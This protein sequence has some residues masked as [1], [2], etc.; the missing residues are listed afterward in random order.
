MP[1][2]PH[3]FLDRVHDEQSFLAF[4]RA[5]LADR[6]D[7]LAKEQAPRPYGAGGPNG[8][9]NAT[10]ED[11]LEGAI[12][13]AEA[14]NLGLSQGLTRSNPWRRFAMFLYCGKIYE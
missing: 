1:D 12:A 2:D 14:S 10:I 9:E 4:A 5:L 6:F 8:W 7:A 11:F 13:W 3:D